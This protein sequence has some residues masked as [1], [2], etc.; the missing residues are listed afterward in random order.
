[1][2]DDEEGL[3]CVEFTGVHS[4]GCEKNLNVESFCAVFAN[5]PVYPLGRI[6]SCQT[7]VI[8]PAGFRRSLGLP[9]V[10]LPVYRVADQVD[11]THADTLSPHLKKP[12]V[13][14]LN[15]D[16]G[17]PHKIVVSNDLDGLVFELEETRFLM[18][19]CKSFGGLSMGTSVG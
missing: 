10:D 16:R 5:G 11:D 1:M 6:P 7:D 2:E 12:K 15:G 19:S 13:N 17:S 9:D 8:V 3:H 18:A 4:F 14:S